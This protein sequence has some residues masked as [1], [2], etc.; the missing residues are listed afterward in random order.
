[1]LA[2]SVLKRLS[3]NFKNECSGKKEKCLKRYLSNR[4]VLSKDC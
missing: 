2:S 3:K 1:M 4:P